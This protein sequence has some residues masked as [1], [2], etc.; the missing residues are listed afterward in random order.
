MK[1]YL[2]ILF[3]I[4]APFINAQVPIEYI[5][6]ENFENN[7]NGWTLTNEKNFV[8][9]IKDNNL[10]LKN[11]TKYFKKASIKTDL[12]L[13][14]DFKI[15]TSIKL[16]SGTN[17]NLLSLKFNKDAK[18]KNYETHEEFGFTDNG[19]WKYL[20]KIS[21]KYIENTGW[22]QTT[23]IKPK[24]F[25]K[26]TILKINEKVFFLI[27]D[28]P[29][30][31]KSNAEFYEQEMALEI[32]NNAKVVFD[33]LKL[34]YLKGSNSEKENWS[35]SLFKKIETAKK[36]KE[37]VLIEDT[38]TQELQTNFDEN[39][40]GFF[41]KE[42]E[43]YN[44]KI[45][46]GAL[47]MENK[48]KDYYQTWADI[49]INPTQNFDISTSVKRVSGTKNKGISLILKDKVKKL[50]FA[51]APNGHWFS[52][53]EKNDKELHFSKWQKT[54]LVKESD[55]NSMRIKKIGRSIYF[56]LND[57]VVN[58][59]EGKEAGNTIYI[60]IPD[61][62][63][64]HVDDFKLTQSFNSNKEQE[65][66]ITE[67]DAL[68]DDAKR[69]NVGAFGK[70]EKQQIAFDKGEAKFNKKQDK[71][72]KKYNRMFKG[73]PLSEVIKKLG[74]PYKSNNVSISYRYNDAYNGRPQELRVAFMPYRKG[75]IT[76]KRVEY[77]TIGYK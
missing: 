9:E 33:Y 59:V 38:I 70:T 10:Y 57:K 74:Q 64:I 7:K 18:T 58:K 77:V 15:E 36:A 60:K 72:E 43:N 51:V 40:F 50:Q 42:T 1:N 67:Y 47:E 53:V 55:H 28:K 46:N 34:G 24:E 26:L 71:V 56:I 4:L 32:P 68:W 63:K 11:E 29:V 61:S 76:Y 66:L 44:F 21:F 65:K 30:L 52:N 17:N 8:S 75:N 6:E 3:L 22:L 16:L 73:A 62:I 41:L 49:K 37:E 2:L 23:N 5:L 27:N 39:E 13:K 35:N 54:N 31:V 12:N 14:K 45:D 48:S 19:Y 20:K 25:N 69:E